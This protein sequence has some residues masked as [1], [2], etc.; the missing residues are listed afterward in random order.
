MPLDTYKQN[1]KEILT[2]PL[3]AAHQPH[4]LLVTPP[5]INEYALDAPK[6]DENTIP[7]RTRTA[8]HTKTYADA[9]REVGE[10][11]GVVV[12]DLW[13]IFMTEAGWK[14][15]DPLPGSKSVERSAVLEE[16]LHDGL[17]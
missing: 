3:L 1:I 9:C 11:L 13:T 8:E 7:T 2:H 16:L 12:L 10:E 6:D 15:D 14:A 17:C 4:L 5:P